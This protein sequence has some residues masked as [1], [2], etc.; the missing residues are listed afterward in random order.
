MFWFRF[1]F[2]LE[3]LEKSGKVAVRCC[4]WWLVV[5]FFRGLG[6]RCVVVPC[7]EH[8]NTER[9]RRCREGRDRGSF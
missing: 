8:N 3:N 7:F 2:S 6:S 5:L 4:W 1:F 9:A